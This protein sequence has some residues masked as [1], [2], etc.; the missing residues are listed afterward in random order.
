M[1]FIAD[2]MLGSLARWLRILGYDV[3]YPPH[4]DDNELVRLAR[5]EGR[6]LLTRD[7]ALARRKG[8]RA[9][10]VESNGLEEQ[11]CQFVQHWGESPGGPFS[12][13]PICNTPLREAS[14]EE[15]EDRVPSYVLRAQENFSLCPGCGRVYWPGTHWNE[16]QRRI[17]NLQGAKE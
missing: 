14:K 9:F 17:A 16:M 8:L 7:V 4:A 15:V 2:N 11:I 6:V 1:K 5:T 10:L 12:R 3:T 13:C